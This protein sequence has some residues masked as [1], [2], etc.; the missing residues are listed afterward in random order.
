MREGAN[1]TVMASAAGRSLEIQSL[2]SHLCGCLPCHQQEYNSDSTRTWVRPGT[3]LALM[4]SLLHKG[5]P[6]LCHQS[7]KSKV[8]GHGVIGIRA[9][10]NYV[11]W[12]MSRRRSP[13][14]TFVHWV[15]LH[16]DSHKQRM[17]QAVVSPLQT[18]TVR[19]Y[20]SWRNPTSLLFPIKE[21]CSINNIHMLCV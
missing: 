21:P 6:R 2:Q 8:G 12:P 7:K 4:L 11:T 20:R 18:P 9:R 3:H 15:P 14:S 1:R 5:T 17:K 16:S 10:P 19:S 13:I